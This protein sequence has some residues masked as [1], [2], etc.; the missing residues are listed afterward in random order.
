MTVPPL[1][2]PP[3]SLGV[4]S[5]DPGPDRVLLWTHLDEGGPCRWEVAT[6]TTFDDIVATGAV[7]TD[8]TRGLV[9]VDVTDLEPGTRYWYRFRQ[10]AATST[11][12]RTRTLPAHGADRLHVGVTCC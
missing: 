8:L 5:F 7:E 1:P 6:D 3:F 12:G 11:T 10:G 9:T 2:A 4:A